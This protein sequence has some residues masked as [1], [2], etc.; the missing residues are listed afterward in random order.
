[1]K[2]VLAIFLVSI[3]L[4]LA[5]TERAEQLENLY[6]T[7]FSSDAELQP[8]KIDQ[9]VEDAER[10]YAN[11]LA[12]AEQAKFQEQAE[13]VKMLAEVRAM[14]C[15]QKSMAVW[16]DRRLLDMK[17]NKNLLNFI[18]LYW[19]GFLDKCRLDLKRL[20]HQAHNK[21]D[22][23]VLMLSSNINLT[24]E[25]L[26]SRLNAA[27]TDAIR[28]F[29]EL[30]LKTTRVNNMELK[31]KQYVKSY[32]AQISTYVSSI[33]DKSYDFEALVESV[34]RYREFD[35]TFVTRMDEDL[36]HELE[37][38]LVFVNLQ[39]RGVDETAR[40]LVARTVD[41]NTIEEQLFAQDSKPLQP[42]DSRRLLESYVYLC[43]HIYLGQSTSTQKYRLAK[44]YH[45]PLDESRCSGDQIRGFYS[46]PPPEVYV[47]LLGYYHQFNYLYSER[48][49]Q[50]LNDKFYNVKYSSG[51]AIAIVEAIVGDNYEGMEFV[52]QL[53]LDKSRTIEVI[54]LQ[55]DRA[56]I[57]LR[58]LNRDEQLATLRRVLG[59][60]H[61]EMCS[62]MDTFE[63]EFK[64]FEG[65]VEYD[66]ASCH[67]LGWP[68]IS[69]LACRELCPFIGN[70][71][72]RDLLDILSR[73]LKSS[74]LTE[75]I[76]TGR[77]NEF[78]AKRTASI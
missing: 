19:R 32:A 15:D 14:R 5:A 36:T 44:Y 75:Q 67:T 56:L 68:V 38:I 63:V 66:P 33:L 13:R 74:D 9:L 60:L 78:W 77:R 39:K 61:D 62:E 8:K 47:N 55:L 16:D 35:P 17:A 72:K 46:K 57:Q 37:Q 22:Q 34:W 26:Y 27:D 70:M 65:L 76:V 24:I 42:E 11:K 25:Q 51:T 12:A 10:V 54:S 6:R 21:I 4:H 52:P 45:L 53:K 3:W 29:D 43:D 64:P 49:L 73:L 58:G 1:M 41:I 30:I 50:F 18:N 40:R 23:T 31:P 20:I 69:F 59:I 71:G 28:A 2:N 48:C 7:L